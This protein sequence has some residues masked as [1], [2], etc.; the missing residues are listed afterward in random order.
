MK[1]TEHT[2][3][4]YRILQ[5]KGRTLQWK[6]NSKR[7]SVV[8]TCFKL[9]PNRALTITKGI[10]DK[11]K[12]SRRIAKRS[13]IIQY[14][15][16]LQRKSSLAVLFLFLLIVGLLNYFLLPLVRRSFLMKVSSSIGR[17][18]FS[19]N[20]IRAATLSKAAM[21]SLASTCASLAMPPIGLGTYGIPP[22]SVPQAISTAIA[23]GYRRIDCA[24]VYF[25]EDAIGDALQ[26][27]FNSGTIDRKDLFITSKLPG[28]FHHREHVEIAV[29]KTLNDL[30]LD[31]LDLYL[32]H[33]PIAFKYVDIDPNKRGYDNE[34]IDNSNGGELI[35]P[36]VSVAE[37]WSA[38]EDLVDKG[39]VR[40]IGVS[41]FP[42]SLLH[43][44]MTSC[45]VKPAV[46]QVEI[47]PYLQQTKLLNYCAARGVHVQAYSPLGTPGYKENDEPSILDDPVLKDMAKKKAVTVGQLALAWS[48]QRGC[49]VTPKSV[50][51]H[52]QKENLASAKVSLTDEE[53]QE[54]AQLDRGYRF[55][56]PEDWWGAMA[57][58]LFD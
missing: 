29:R 52:R 13:H 18:F 49:S 6:R 58:A 45:R 4:D 21:T 1:S 8:N 22:S 33:W 53:M 25:N 54:F 30:R 17:T 38:M 50:S 9:D 35:D 32:I 47:H 16:L 12:G 5:A 41:N 57:L 7:L 23:S 10:H 42:V 11:N 56:R 37:T 44:L 40:H 51:D 14:P 46:N 15:S 19:K 3:K 31:Y 43:E 24:P 26:S 27:E 28:P 55:F 34:D 36:T 39:L 2:T 48:L 20:T